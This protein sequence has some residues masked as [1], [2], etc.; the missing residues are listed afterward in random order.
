CSL[1]RCLPC[2]PSSAK[3]SKLC[4]STCC[5][6]A[7]ARPPWSSCNPS[8]SIRA[9][10]ASGPTASAAASRN[11]ST[12]RRRC[13][14]HW[15]SLHRLGKGHLRSLRARHWILDEPFHPGASREP[16]QAEPELHGFFA[17]G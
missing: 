16:S 17:H 13:P 11:G 10:R 7:A 14:R 2:A 5:V 9:N 4:I 3:I 6:Q 8:A 1:S 15:A 12:K